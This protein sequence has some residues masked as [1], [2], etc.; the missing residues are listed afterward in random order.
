MTQTDLPPARSLPT[1]ARR[2]EPASY[3]P[4][5]RSTP[6]RHRDRASFDRATVHAILDE[7]L[8]AH[9]AFVADDGTPRLLPTAYA[10]AGE[11]LVLHGSTGSRWPSLDGKPVCVTVTLLDAVVLAR[12]WTHHSMAYRSV[13][14]HGTAR[15]LRDEDERIAAM[16]A[17]LDHIAPGRSSDTR[18]PTAKESA[19][20]AVLT[21]D[22]DE[23][24]AK[25]RGSHV[26]E[27]PEDIDGP[28]WAG[29]VPLRLVAGL[30]VPS[31]TLRAGIPTPGVLRD[32]RRPF[33]RPGQE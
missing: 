9:V 8:V 18:P 22:L 14:V 19:A 33:P 25:I 23:S 5:A 4:T 1:P 31:D 27:E 6:T 15:R 30:P 20:I 17:L 16:G 12:S 28:Y 13:I 10:R 29:H 21:V 3:Q 26:G 24:T 2:D 7:G 11:R 32:Y